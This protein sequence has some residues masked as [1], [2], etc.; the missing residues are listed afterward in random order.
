MDGSILWSSSILSEDSR[1]V[2]PIYR[3]MAGIEEEMASSRPTHSRG[4]DHTE[5]VDDHLPTGVTLE[6]RAVE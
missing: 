3:R 6:E 2:V 5:E 4:L 1:R